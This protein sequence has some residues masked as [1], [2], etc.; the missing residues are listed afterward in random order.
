MLCASIAQAEPAQTAERLAARW[1]PVYVQ[2]VADNDRGADRPTRIDFDGNWD[3]TD[4][5]IHQR[6]L[7]TA[8]PP[9]VYTA[10]ILTATHAYVTY[11]LFYPRDWSRFC[12]SLIC[13]DNDL[14][15]V[16]LVIERDDADGSLVEIRT[17]AHHHI[18]RTT[19]S[20]IARTADGRP[21]FRVE[22]HGHGIAPCK[23]NDPACQPRDGRIVY[24]LGERAS[25]PPAHAT[26]QT[27]R[28]ELLSLHSTLWPRRHL[29]ND[30]L[31]IEGESGPLYYHGAKRGRLGHA[32]GASMAQANY[33]GGV[34]PPWA[35]AGPTG[36]RG[37]WFLDPAQGSR[38]E[39]NP[40]LE[41]LGKECE[42]KRCKAAP[43]ERSKALY[44]LKLG[45]PY[46]GLGLGI[47]GV[48][49]WMRLR[50]AGLPF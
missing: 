43:R 18:D 38:Y 20:D 34:R 39:F 15:S 50:G 16:Q 28:Y 9:A 47:V 41:D 14:E 31:W 22:S 23:Q 48:A 11:T 33:A 21:M 40:Y 27:V 17:K 5:W 7:G 42:G 4:N 13:H 12:V 1:A 10:P 8:L 32:M 37:D 29:A 25:S 3:A 6:E 2:H 36:K 44:L 26:G 46:I 35:L 45:A 49:G 30:R 24:A 19:G